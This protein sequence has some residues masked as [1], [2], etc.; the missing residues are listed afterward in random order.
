[1][2]KALTEQTLLSRQGPA[3]GLPAKGRRAGPP[4]AGRRAVGAAGGDAGQRTD[5]GGAHGSRGSGL[6]ALR[7]DLPGI[8]DGSLAERGARR[9]AGA[10]RP[11]G[12][13]ADSRTGGLAEPSPRLS[14]RPTSPTQ[15][16]LQETCTPA[17]PPSSRRNSCGSLA[18][19]PIGPDPGRLFD[20]EAS[21]SQRPATLRRSIPVR[22]VSTSWR[23]TASSRDWNRLFGTRSSFTAAAVVPAA[24]NLRAQ[25]PPGCCATC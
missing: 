21:L 16:E 14:R 23:A 10:A 6:G 19:I 24:A 4:Q 11:G 7:A 25:D 22:S 2:R 13:G 17:D 8:S 18:L 1:M 20:L 15:F 5:G 3:S 9:R 12:G